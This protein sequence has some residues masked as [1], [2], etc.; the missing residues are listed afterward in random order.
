MKRRAFLAAGTGALTVLLPGCAL[1]PEPNRRAAPPGV[2][3]AL[4][5]LLAALAAARAASVPPA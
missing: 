2:D 3:A 1:L 5:G 4:A